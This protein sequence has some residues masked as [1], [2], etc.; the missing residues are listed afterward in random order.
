[1]TIFLRSRLLISFALLALCG[2]NSGCDLGTYA[3]RAET[4]S[5]SYQAPKVMMPKA[6]TEEEKQP[7]GASG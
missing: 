1:M 5:Q 3:Q 7:E 4:S 2:L 6:N